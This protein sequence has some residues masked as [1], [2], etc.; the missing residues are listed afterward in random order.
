MPATYENDIPPLPPLDVALS[1]LFNLD[2]TR[3]A[4]AHYQN[5]RHLFKDGALGWWGGVIQGTLSNQFTVTNVFSSEEPGLMIHDIVQR[6]YLE[7]FSSDLAATWRRAA[8]YDEVEDKDIWTICFWLRAAWIS[9]LDA[10]DDEPA[11]L[12]TPGYRGGL[13]LHPHLDSLPPRPLIEDLFRDRAWADLVLLTARHELGW[14]YRTIEEWHD[15]AVK[16]VSSISDASL[17]PCLTSEHLERLSMRTQGYYSYTL[18]ATDSTDVAYT[19]LPPGERHD[20]PRQAFHAASDVVRLYYLFTQWYRTTYDQT[21]R[22]PRCAWEGGCH[23]LRPKYTG[24]G[25]RPTLCPQHA[26]ESKRKGDTE[27]Q[28][29]H[30]NNRSAKRVTLNNT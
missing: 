17:G 20:A 14:Y 18:T 3:D 22:E 4:L 28:R 16:E 13:F 24:R 27:R 12:S 9:A 21:V 29:R 6:G 2:L 5:N 25:P 11:S 26:L 15:A 1:H 19:Y 23:N 7:S 30:R 8:G 10:Y